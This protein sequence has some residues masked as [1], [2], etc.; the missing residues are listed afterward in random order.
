MI[1]GQE[2]EPS[3]TQFLTYVMGTVL[4]SLKGCVTW[5][6]SLKFSLV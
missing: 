1:S 6:T 3:V 5:S 4:P 2:A